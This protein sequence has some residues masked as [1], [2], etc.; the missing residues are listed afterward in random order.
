MASKDVD[1]DFPDGSV[2]KNLAAYAGDLGSVPGSERFPGEG[3]GN[4]PTPVFLP[5]ESYG[6]RSLVGCSP[7]G[8]KELD[9]T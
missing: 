4:P 9:I 6:Q 3:N 2:V 5:R 7:R 8:C 1:F